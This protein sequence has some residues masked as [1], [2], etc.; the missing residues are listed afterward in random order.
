MKAF[1]SLLA[2]LF[3][4]LPALSLF[5]GE[6]E[7][8]EALKTAFRERKILWEERSLLAEYGGFG[9]SLLIRPLP[10]GRDSKEAEDAMLFVLAVPL[11]GQG[12]LPDGREE[13]EELPLRFRAALSLI[14]KING[15]T[16]AGASRPEIIVAFLGDEGALPPE[17]AK[18]PRRGLED[19]LNLLEDPERT[20]LWYLDI[21]SREA[22]NHL[23]IH[24]GTA[25]GIASLG[26]IR[27]IPGL[28]EELSIPWSFAAPFNG[29]YKLRLLKGP[30]V[31]RRV[32]EEGTDALYISAGYG[33]L[34]SPA[35]T[36]ENLGEF[37]YRYLGALDTSGARDRHYAMT[38]LPLATVFL[39]EYAIAVFFLA[40]GAVSL[41][42]LLIFWNRRKRLFS[43]VKL[44]S[45]I[46]IA[47]IGAGILVSGFLD[48]GF[49][50]LWA[51]AFL[52]VLPAGILHKPVPFFAGTFLAMG[53]I[54][55][56]GFFFFRQGEVPASALPPIRELE[57][58]GP[59]LSPGS[60]KGEDFSAEIRSRKL[61]SLRI[62][63]LSLRSREKP[64]RFDVSLSSSAPPILIH[65]APVPF[66][67]SDNS[68]RAEFFLGEDPPNP[69]N[70]EI[71][72]SGD[73]RG[74]LQAEALFGSEDGYLR[75]RKEIE[76]GD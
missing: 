7:R 67:L 42:L 76:I 20:V 73:F 12:E 38:Q 57:A 15:E 68:D 58:P 17:I 50:P 5:C 75:I 44:S 34:P 2:A 32:F 31:L 54:V 46:V 6:R 25:E 65:S 43:G 3:F 24:H 14:D 60:G 19:V 59:G 62:I 71:Y 63:D 74:V 13:A 52:F 41:L 72:L 26:I 28:C 22:P 21:G 33:P 36:G 49:I 66:A 35:L 23:E 29:L 16:E 37:I 61:L 4:L 30:P 69:L 47:L 53:Y 55:W 18:R 48:I 70:M 27:R 39:S 11:T 45:I 1:S 64:L 9:S 56:A 51:A 8:R 10:P 40:G